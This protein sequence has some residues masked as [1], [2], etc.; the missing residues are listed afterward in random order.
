MHS[1]I[2]PSRPSQSL[3]CPRVVLPASG[4]GAGSREGDLGDPCLPPPPPRAT[5]GVRMCGKIR[6]RD[7]AFLE[8]A[9]HCRNGPARVGGGATDPQVQTVGPVF[10]PLRWQSLL[11]VNY[12]PAKQRT[13]PSRD[14][15]EQKPI[16]ADKLGFFFLSPSSSHSLKDPSLPSVGT[17]SKGVLRMPEHPR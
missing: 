16:T 15:A 5:A 1:R 12:L 3:I 13:N 10:R 7:R 4:L 2:F 6:P 9:C 8:A 17:A 11:E 14:R